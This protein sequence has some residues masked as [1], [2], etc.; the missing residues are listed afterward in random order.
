MSRI[1]SHET[2]IEEKEARNVDPIENVKGTEHPED[3]MKG[4]MLKHKYNS[5]IDT[6]IHIDRHLRTL[7]LTPRRLP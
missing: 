1:S 6:K 2:V 4:H 7:L 3:D 5:K